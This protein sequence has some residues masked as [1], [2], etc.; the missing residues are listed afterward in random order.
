MIAIIDYNMGNLRSVEKAIQV[1]GGKTRVTSRPGD[2]RDADK[3]VL[4]GVGSFG[5]AMAELKR[6]KLV[7]PIKESISEGKPFLGLCLGM[8]LLFE[9]SE[10]SPG[11][12]GL[13]VL[14]GNVRRFKFT[15]H[16]RRTT[17]DALKVPHMGWNNIVKS[18]KR[19]VKSE[20]I[21]KNVP[22]RAYMY[23]VHSY[24]VKPKDRDVVLT[25]TDYGIDFVSGVARGNTLG[26]QFHPEKS[27][28]LGLRILK[29]F[30]NLKG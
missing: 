26:F 23:F 17:N 28:A 24:Y 9:K 14:A 29:N 11:V 20:R 27:Q 16:E 15:N 10:E 13:G 12:N 7:A 1:A 4:P 25:T 22:D 6:L 2:L 30:V 5:A 8:Q 21:L 3:V 18:E 19:K